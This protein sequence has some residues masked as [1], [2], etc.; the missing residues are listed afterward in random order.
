M[1]KKAVVHK[2]VYTGPQI[3]YVSRDGK[4]SLLSFPHFS[5]R[6]GVDFFSSAMLAAPC[7]AHC[8]AVM[9]DFV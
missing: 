1:K 2:E 6:T 8:S 4:C 7:C 3:S 9:A 5:S